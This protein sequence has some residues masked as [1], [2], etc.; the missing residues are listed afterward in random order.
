MPLGD[1]GDI[2]AWLRQEHAALRRARPKPVIGKRAPKVV[3][4]P[5][6]VIDKRREPAYRAGPVRVYRLDKETPATQPEAT[7][8]DGDNTMVQWFT[9]APAPPTGEA[10]CVSVYAGGRLWL[11]RAVCE[12]LGTGQQVQVGLTSDDRIALRIVQET[13]A[14]WRIHPTKYGWHIHLAVLNRPDLVGRHV[15]RWDDALQ[16]WITHRRL[17]LRRG[18]A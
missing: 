4:M 14:G 15:L 1:T 8:Q 11:P 16:C 17:P 10:L 18:T 2:E 7:Q 13:E 5:S 3:R 6:D 12:A 9:P